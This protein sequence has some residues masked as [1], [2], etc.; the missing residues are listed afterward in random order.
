MLRATSNEKVPGSTSNSY[1]QDQLCNKCS[2]LKPVEIKVMPRGKGAPME[3]QVEVEAEDAGPEDAGGS[4]QDESGDDDSGAES[5][6]F[7]PGT[8]VW[9][10]VRSWHPGIILAPHDVPDSFSNLL[11]SCSTESVF[12]KRFKIDDIKIVS[13]K[14]LDTLAGNKVD[15][16]RACKS[17]DI[18]EAYEIALSLQRDDF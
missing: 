7:G 8:I 17:A 1:F 4:D 10:R 2:D 11:N 6:E 3:E 12:I 15:R 5:E 18:R 14:R 13:I 9:A 16:E